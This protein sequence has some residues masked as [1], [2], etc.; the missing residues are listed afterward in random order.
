MTIGKIKFDKD[1][2]PILLQP[3]TYSP[4]NTQNT[5]TYYEAFWGLYLPITTTFRVCDIWRSY[6]VQRLLWDIGGQL[7]FGT[8]TIRQIRNSH[9]Y[10]K[11]MI[12]EDQL[13]HQTG[14]FVRFLSAWS[15]SS[16]TLVQR[17]L[18]L[19][20]AI[21]DAGFWKLD[22]TKIINAWIDDLRSVG[23]IFP[24]IVPTSPSSSSSLQHKRAAIC[25]TGVTE[26]I[27]EA[28]TKNYQHIRNSLSGD[29]DTF[30]YL[31][32]SMS[33]GP[34]SLHTRLKQVRSYMNSTVTIIYED[35]TIDPK[36][37]ADCQTN[38]I[39]PKHV[40]KVDAYF[41]QVWALAQ[42]YHL[43]ERYEKEFNIKYQVLIRSR[44]DILSGNQFTLERDGL[45]NINT[46]ILAPPNRFFNELDD[47]FA[48]GPI[49]LMYHYMTRWYSFSKC[50]PG[51]LYHSETYLTRYLKGFTNVTRDRTL[52]AAADALPHGKNHCH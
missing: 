42:C 39:L 44:V 3:Y 4:Y 36:I 40:Y 15:S 8:S 13:Y 16:P 11:D 14:S 20:R 2:L 17:I 41:Q 49:E 31:S 27:N 38:F 28:W 46:T 48:V 30:L 18:Q 47:G 6:W 45:F 9:S 52:P 34:V 12:E 26:C 43:V 19:T 29:V 23:Y 50:P 51:G 7:M 25:A 22:E 37:P 5:I 32:S 10:L 24:A 1:Q 35:R 21:A 33:A